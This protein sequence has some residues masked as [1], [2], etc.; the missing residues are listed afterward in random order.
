MTAIDYLK[1]Y[2]WSPY[3][4]GA[5]IGVLSWFTFY[6]AGQVLGTSTPMVNMVGIA[7][8]LL[9]EDLIRNNAYLADHVVGK[10]AFNWQMALVFMLPIGAFLGARLAG[11]RRVEYMPAVWKQRFGNSRSRRYL[12]A[13]L[14]GMIMLFGAR[15]AGGCTSGHGISGGL[16]LALSSWVFMIALFGS[17]IATALLIYPKNKNS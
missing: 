12:W 7:G 6:F 1:K 8:G 3:A 13:F 11:S 2:P 4:A 5:G 14:G 9:S 10:P 17:G 15:L 16:Q